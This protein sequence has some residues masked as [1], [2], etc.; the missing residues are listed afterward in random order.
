MRFVLMIE[1]QQGATYADQLAIA[2]RAEAAG[3]EAFFRSDHYESFPG[4]TDNPTTDAWAVLAGLA[5]ETTSIG[6]GILVTPVTYRQPGNIAKLGATVAE[7]SGGRLEVGVGA[8]WHEEEHRRHGFPFPP[9]EER[10]EMLEETLEILHGLWEGADGW[11]FAGRHY[12]VDDAHFRARPDP[13][14]RIIVGGSGTPRSM[15]LAARWA[16]EFNLTSSAPAAVAAKYAELDRACQAIDRDPTTL[17]RSAMIG[18][19]V[20][21]NADEV[22]TRQ[23]AILEAFGNDSEA[24]A[25]FGER[26]E[27]WIMG[28]PDEARATVERFAQ[29]GVER[30]MLQDFLPWDLEMIDLLG[31]ELVRAG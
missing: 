25:W 22:G 23:R 20:G 24:D 1:A 5:R 3:F 29:A 12:R 14:P 8:G 16:D 11:S 13:R 26:S 19:L 28:T 4:S 21:R 10:A 30:L 2:R 9:I 7:M 17:T 31:E 27:R 15:R 6:L 18:T